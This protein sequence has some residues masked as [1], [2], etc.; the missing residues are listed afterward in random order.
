[1]I[2]IV[3][4]IMGGILLGIKTPLLSP[5][6]YLSRKIKRD[7]FLILFFFYCL[8][9]CFEFKVTNIY[10]TNLADVLVVLIPT[11]LLLD[12]GLRGDDI[13]LKDF[14]ASL[15]LSI[16]FVSKLLFTIIMLILTIYHFSK[17]NPRK[18]VVAVLLSLL[19]LIIGFLIFQRTLNLIGS[20]STQAIFLSSLSV[21]IILAFSK[22]N[23]L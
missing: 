9:L 17:D 23:N 22:F 6:V 3:A 4:S 20:A 5:I 16:G 14:V 21:L 13:S 10:S 19:T 12:M 2:A 11:V 1:M 15:S 18:G 8:A 7:V